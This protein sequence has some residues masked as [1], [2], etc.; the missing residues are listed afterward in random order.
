MDRA[1][2]LAAWRLPPWGGGLA[3]LRRD[4]IGRSG[5]G[6]SG[7]GRS[8]IGRSGGSDAAA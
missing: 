1:E 4:G 5:A 6:R 8:G 2:G 7:I 3:A